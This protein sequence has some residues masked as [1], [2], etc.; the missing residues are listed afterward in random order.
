MP[1]DDRILI[2]VLAAR[3][4]RDLADSLVEGL[5]SE[6]SERIGGH[7]TWQVEVC[8]AEPAD[9]TAGRSDLTEAV[10]RRL[11]DRGWQMGVGLTSLP[12]RERRR[13][14]TALTSAGYGVG[15][16]SIPAL[17]ALHRDE[18]LR[19]AAVE[20]VEGLLG[21]PADERDE[22]SRD[23]RMRRRSADLASP[24]ATRDAER[25][26]TLAFTGAAA[27]GNLRLLIG[28]IRANR[29]TLVMA[30]LSRSA[31]AALGTGAY[32]LTSSSIWIVAHQSTWPRLLAVALLSMVL[33]LLALVIA[34]GLWERTDDPNARERVV[35]FNIVTVATLAIGIAAL[36]LALFAIVAVAAAV[37]IPPSAFKQQ[38]SAAPTVGDYA[39]LAWFA[40][41]VA[42]VGGAL[43][44]LVE[45]DDAV[46]DA[47]YRPRGGSS[48]S[49]EMSGHE[50]DHS[51]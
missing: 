19:E 36:Y 7:T 11:L 23:A 31:T 16:V 32:A 21:E 20:V 17:G 43:G 42:T 27:R 28:M 50:R 35:L 4:N 49:A 14:V 9:S 22:E 5:P 18:R 1:A 37:V 13:P 47:A 15:L 40:A 44:S 2:G 46:R 30:R 34:H 51:T 12:L 25:S 38:L 39:R 24:I 26:G 45:S 41:S 29:P 48:S 6:L 3:D 10:R 8:E 33:I